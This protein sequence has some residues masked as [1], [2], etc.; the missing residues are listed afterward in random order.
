MRV[1]SEIRL[2]IRGRTQPDGDSCG[3]CAMAAVYRYYGLDPATRGFN[4]RDRLGV[5][6]IVPTALTRIP[7]LENLRIPLPPWL[8]GTLPFDMFNVLHE[9]GFDVRTAPQQFPACV[10]ALLKHLQ[11][12]HPALACVDSGS[13]WVVISG[14]SRTGLWVADSAGWLAR[15]TYY[16]PFDEYQARRIGEVLVSRHKHARERDVSVANVTSAYARATGAI[17][18]WA[19]GK[20]LEAVGR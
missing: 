8:R 17:V 15:P 14:I 4:L 7:G 10:R 1:P 12:G 2:P 3:F 9:D 13:H 5:D 11:R 18:R 19:G 16:Q 20:L 6:H